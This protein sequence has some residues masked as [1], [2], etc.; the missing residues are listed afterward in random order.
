PAL[1]SEVVPKLMEQPPVPGTAIA[2]VEHGRIVL[3]RGYGYSRLDPNL[4]VDAS[5][6]LF[7]IGSV[8]KVFTSVAALQLAEAG[9]LDLKR[10]IRGYAPDISLRYGAT[11]H[12]LLTH[13][14]GLDEVFSIRSH[15]P[16]FWQ[17]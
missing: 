9:Y 8:S 10:D 11:T 15:D 7:R 16:I 6:T 2:I 17:S 4:P 1:I 12:Q 5:R 3:P 13:T 14:A